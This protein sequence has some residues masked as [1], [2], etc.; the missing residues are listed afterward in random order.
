MIGPFE[1]NELLA[2]FFVLLALVA[3]LGA[4]LHPANTANTSRWWRRF[5]VML[6]FLL[7]A[8]VATNAEQLY[9]ETS[10]AHQLMNLVEHLAFAAAGLWAAHISMRGISFAFERG[11]EAGE[12]VT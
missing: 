9:P 11:S 6:G 2:V 1:I 10:L 8:Q 12:R 3:T 5:L 7:L 4:R